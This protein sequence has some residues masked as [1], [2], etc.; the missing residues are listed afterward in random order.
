MVKLVP[1]TMEKYETWLDANVKFYAEEKVRSGNVS[2]EEAMQVSQHEFEQIMPDGLDTLDTYLFN[3]KDEDSDQDVGSLWL[4]VRDEGKE[5]FIYGIEINEDAR[6][7]GYGRQTMQALEARVKQMGIPK[8]SLH[9]FGYNEV[10]INLYKSS[11]YV[12]TNILMSK[13]LTE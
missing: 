3:V 9:V 4:K 10:A 13:V 1:M 7:K 11:G 6:G 2:A 8:I 12:A 5:M